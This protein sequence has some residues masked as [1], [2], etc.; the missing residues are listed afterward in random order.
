MHALHHNSPA[1]ARPYPLGAPGLLKSSIW[2][3]NSRPVDGDIT[4][5]PNTVLTVVV[6]LTAFPA[7]STTALQVKGSG[8]MS[9]FGSWP[10]YLVH[11]LWAHQCLET[12]RFSEFDAFGYDFQPFMTSF[13][14]GCAHTH[15]VRAQLFAESIPIIS[16]VPTFPVELWGNIS[17][18]RIHNKVCRSNTASD[19]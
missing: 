14:V 9:T 16:S 17:L 4:L 11:R 6:R 2:L 10:N 1:G 7:A 15:K 12:C 19:I 13:S 18:V 5:L 8:L 3:L